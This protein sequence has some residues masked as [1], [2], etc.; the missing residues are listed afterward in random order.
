MSINQRRQAWL[1]LSA[2]AGLAAWIFKDDSQAEMA[3]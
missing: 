3:T 1:S 2:F